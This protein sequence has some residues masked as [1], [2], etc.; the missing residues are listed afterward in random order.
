MWTCSALLTYWFSVHP[1]VLQR[2][3][4][5]G[6]HQCHV[7][8]KYIVLFDGM[9]TGQGVSADIFLSPSR[10]SSS[11]TH[12][13]LSQSWPRRHVRWYIRCFHC[14]APTPLGDHE[15][16]NGFFFSRSMHSRVIKARHTRTGYL[17]YVFLFIRVSR[18]CA[19][20]SRH[21]L[22]R[23]WMCREMQWWHRQ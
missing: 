12:L 15:L 23:N 11:W 10:S 16:M 20:I 8:S 6:S 21:R 19:L 7:G 18:L 3:P 4:F 22:I 5:F 17:A 9:G 2:N 1:D 14:V 13:V